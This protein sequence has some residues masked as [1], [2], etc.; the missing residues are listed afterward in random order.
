[1]NAPAGNAAT[2][3][4]D[5]DAVTDNLLD[6]VLEQTATLPPM[7]TGIAVGQLAGFDAAGLPLVHVPALR[8][9]SVSARSMV[10]LTGEQIGRELALGFEGSDPHRPIVL[11]LMLGAQPAPSS[12]SVAPAPD[13]LNVWVDGEHIALHAAHEIE[14]RCGEAAIVMTADGRITLRGTYITSHASATQ[15]ILGGSVNLN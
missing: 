3:Q 4:P 11:G 5:T 14:L 1:M 8:L 15:R 10:V 7:A 6:S 2:P 13:Q 9:T 12:A